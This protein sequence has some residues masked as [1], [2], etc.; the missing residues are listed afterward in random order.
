MGRAVTVAL[1]NTRSYL[2][3]PGAYIRPSDTVLNGLAT[4]RALMGL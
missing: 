4:A 3:V 2:P 1:I